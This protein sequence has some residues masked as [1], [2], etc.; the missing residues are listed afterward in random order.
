MLRH[1]ATRRPKPRDGTNVAHFD[2]PARSG[3]PRASTSCHT[4]EES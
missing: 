4:G 2:P 3:I 1:R